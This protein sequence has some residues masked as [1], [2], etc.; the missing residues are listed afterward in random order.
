MYDGRITAQFEETVSEG[1]DSDEESEE[2]EMEEEGEEE[3]NSGI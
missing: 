2:G 3:A 1:N